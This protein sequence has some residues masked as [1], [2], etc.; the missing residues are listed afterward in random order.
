MDYSHLT[1]EMTW[2]FS[3]ISTF[4]SCPY[5]FY[6]KYIALAD[7]Q[8][9]FFASYG[10]FI[11]SILERYLSGKLAKDELPLYYLA[12]FFS[13]VSKD[14]PSS[15]IYWDYFN[16]AQ[17][18]VCSASFVDLIIHKIEHKMSFLLGGYPFI[19]Y[20][21]L[22]ARN[23]QNQLVLMDH[24][25]KIIK[26]S[27]RSSKPTKDAQQ[28]LRQL[29][30]YSVPIEKEFGQLPD[31]LSINCYRANRVLDYSF[32]HQEFEK[33]KNWALQSIE[34]IHQNRSWLPNIEPF[35]C[36]YICDVSHHCDY[37]QLYKG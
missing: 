10:K 14:A 25:S 18:H 27:K 13:E 1:R 36:R 32:D 9:Q 16:D 28:I 3:R 12:H 34:E 26:D 17:N 37:Y 24:K 5:S 20:A 6:L 2:S 33:A 35:K 22:I 29:Y 11:H 7:T 4:H 15:K 23:R 30:L 19:G 31:I 21:D 8:K